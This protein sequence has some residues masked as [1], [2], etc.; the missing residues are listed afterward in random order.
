MFVP[1]LEIFF[2]TFQAFEVIE[3]KVYEQ[4][5]RLQQLDCMVEW[6][7]VMVWVG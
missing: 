3:I 6:V 4:E 7:K 5:N 1:A 2:E